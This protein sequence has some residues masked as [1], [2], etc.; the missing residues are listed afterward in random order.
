MVEPAE[1]DYLKGWRTAADGDY[2]KL[3]LT[4]G[5]RAS[6]CFIVRAVSSGFILCTPRTAIPQAD[7]EEATASDFGGTLGPWTA[8]T[9]G[10][11]TGSGK[12]L[13]KT[14]VCLL[15]DVNAAG[16]SMLSDQAP[17]TVAGELTSFGSHRLQNVWPLGKGALDALEV[18]LNGDGLED[19][20]ERLEPYFT[21]SSGAEVRPEEPV[22]PGE[23]DSTQR[24]LLQQILAQ[25]ST[26]S[27]II[28][29]RLS[30]L[31]A[32]EAR[33]SVLEERGAP[34]PAEPE[35]KNP[36]LGGAKL[37]GWAPQLFEEG[38]GA[39]LSREQVG[40]LLQ[41]AG[42]APR[43]L[44]DLPGPSSAA[45]GAPKMLAAA[46]K[47]RPGTAPVAG[48]GLEDDEEDGEGAVVAAL[49][50]QTQILSQLATSARKS[51]DPL[52]LLG[53]AGDS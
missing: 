30:G 49:A 5:E 45:R 44:G 22:D 48:V 40:Q 24:E 37:P 43:T 17:L 11:T 39:K 41:L 21:C 27:E 47:I 32:I 16:V 13:K 51:H 33:L 20:P 42:Q 9:L 12:A 25:T 18:F 52:H 19:L 3:F 36:L 46:P 8:A 50:Q 2:S 53:S 23:Q 1:L 4:Y 6:H 31:D 14:A 26:Q 28:Q 34:P 10:V 35:L 15:V 38:A 29:Q 7:L